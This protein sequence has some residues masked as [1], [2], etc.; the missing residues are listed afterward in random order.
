[1]A[2]DFDAEFFAELD[3]LRVQERLLE[4]EH[5]AKVAARYA[6]PLE[7]GEPRASDQIADLRVKAEYDAQELTK[8][9]QVQAVLDLEQSNTL[10]VTEYVELGRMII[11]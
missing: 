7:P 5:S 8:A 9:A 1:M 10:T 4:V 3:Q 6:P 2:T 11:R